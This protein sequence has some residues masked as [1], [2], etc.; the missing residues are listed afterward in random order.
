MAIW[1]AIRA[2]SQGVKSSQLT[3]VSRLLKNTIILSSLKNTRLQ[4]LVHRTLRGAIFIKIATP[5]GQLNPQHQN[6]YGNGNATWIVKH[7]FGFRRPIAQAIIH[8]R[9]VQG[10]VV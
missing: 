10:T 5:V 9:M 2:G 1:K 8:T 3:Q 6:G 4:T 7:I